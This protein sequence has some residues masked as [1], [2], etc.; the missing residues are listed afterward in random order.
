ML[1]ELEN[2][3]RE[4]NEERYWRQSDASLW[5]CQFRVRQC[6]VEDQTRPLD[7]WPRTVVE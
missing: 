7:L 4:L 3:R 2:K 6:E 1:A 5:I